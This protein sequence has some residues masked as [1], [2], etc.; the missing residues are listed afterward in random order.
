MDG[1]KGAKAKVHA[2]RSLSSTCIETK[3]AT[4][5]RKEATDVLGVY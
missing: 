2:M 3:N 1:K 5:I 4:M